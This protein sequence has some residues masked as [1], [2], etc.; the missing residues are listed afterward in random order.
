MPLYAISVNSGGLGLAVG[1]LGVVL[2]TSDGGRQWT[3][4]RG[5]GRRLAMLAVHVTPRTLPLGVV[6]LDS[7]ESGYRSAGFLLS[8]SPS[9]WRAADRTVRALGGQ[10]VAADWRLRLDQ[11]EL[12]RNSEQLEQRWRID[13]EGPVD[14]MLVDRLV[15]LFRTW[16][17]SVVVIDAGDQGDHAARL[18]REAVVRAIRYSADPTRWAVPA[19]LTGLTP[20]AASRLFERTGKSE[21]VA[22][23]VGPGTVMHRHG[24]TVGAVVHRSLLGATSSWSG[25]RLV[26]TLGS[27]RPLGES[28][29]QGLGLAAGSVAR[30]NVLLEPS[31]SGSDGDIARRRGRALSAW[32]QL[33]ETRSRPFSVLLGELPTLLLSLIHI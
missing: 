5:R 29:C 8:A 3:P 15:G 4:V 22:V 18:V 26:R 13:A 19:A 23:R 14:D 10:G 7:A 9:E 20:W 24:E 25:D 6:A 12:A 2:R 27:G 32:V 21:A 16:R 28:A 1:A 33:A 31:K 30:R 17:P 11:P